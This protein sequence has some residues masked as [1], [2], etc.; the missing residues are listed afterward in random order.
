M[1]P[2]KDLTPSSFSSFLSF[3]L[4]FFFFYAAAAKNFV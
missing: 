3:F 4:S 1:R 2:K